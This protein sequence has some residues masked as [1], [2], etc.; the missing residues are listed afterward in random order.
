MATFDCV[1]GCIIYMVLSLNSIHN[2]NVSTDSH[3]P[4][5]GTASSGYGCGVLTA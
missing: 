5:G 3:M 1:P 4:N 2:S